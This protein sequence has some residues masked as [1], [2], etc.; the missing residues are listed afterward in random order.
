MNP[1][2][3]KSENNIHVISVW[4]TGQW[5]SRSPS[6]TQILLDKKGTIGYS[7]ALEELYCAFSNCKF[8]K[9]AFA[10]DSYIYV[11]LNFFV[12]LRIKQEILCI[13]LICSNRDPFHS[14]L[15]AIRT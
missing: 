2:P 6:D 15:K 12:S 11:F 10:L 9:S 8:H 1:S 4:F 5:V 3:S 13:I 7:I 14:N